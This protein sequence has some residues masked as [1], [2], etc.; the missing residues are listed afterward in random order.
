MRHLELEP[1][2]F[3]AAFPGRLL[4]HA[5]DP[6]RVLGEVRPALSAAALLI[7]NEVLDAWFFLDTRVFRAAFWRAG[8]AKL[9]DGGP[10]WYGR[11][12]RGCRASI[13]AAVLSLVA[14]TALPLHAAEP[15]SESS[16]GIVVFA[17]D[18]Q[19]KDAQAMID[20]VRAHLTGLPIRLVI[21]PRG[22]AASGSGS[23][24]ASDGSHRIGTL[25][26][27]PATPGEW[28]V[29]FTEPAI[30]TT[31]VRRIRLKPQGKRVA[32][33]EA[34]IVV[35]SM[36]E[37]ILDGGHVGIAR[38]GLRS[39]E[40]SAVSSAPWR[41]R[42]G[43]TATAGYLGTT[44]G[45]DVGWQS[46]GM[47]GL[48]WHSGAFYAGIA[49]QIFAPIATDTTPVSLLLVRHPGAIVVGYE[50]VS[51]L[52]PTIE[53]EIMADYVTRSN[54]KTEGGYAE[55]APESRW[56]FGIGA[57]AGVSWYFLPRIRLL[58][59]GGIDWILNPYSYL[60]PPYVI[61]Q[62]AAVRPK[63]GIGVAVDLL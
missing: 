9:V 57:M 41:S 32:L 43:I 35:R 25:T 4:E 52:A 37:A 11:P 38:P 60:A 12:V 17:V 55:T 49:T 63:I 2:T 58:G 62:S 40:G 33:E 16:P 46:G 20:A 13:A 22:G 28:V 19:A 14:S 50:G 21:D 27:D 1:E 18:P 44:F 45:S 48:R 5:S 59:Q 42:R 51:R 3:A 36:V 26:I 47:I 39:D 54:R 7:C 61:V 15:V 56:F 31:L 30:D 34:A 29:S 10:I 53:V 23:E 8:R 24:P 6:A